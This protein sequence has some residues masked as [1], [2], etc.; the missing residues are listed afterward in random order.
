MPNKHGKEIFD[1]QISV[2]E[3]LLTADEVA[4]A[5]NV[6][7][8]AIRKWRM[9]GRIP[10]HKLGRLLRFRASEVFAALKGERQ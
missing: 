3:K 6:S 8:A 1:N 5:L 2:A 10:Y 4:K 9:Q 7:G